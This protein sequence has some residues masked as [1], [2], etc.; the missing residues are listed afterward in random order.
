MN[1]MRG[2]SLSSI[3]TGLER[4]IAELLFLEESVQIV[5]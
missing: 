5:A 1:N 4:H 3:D 2:Y